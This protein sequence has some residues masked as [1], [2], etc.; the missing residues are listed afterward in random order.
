MASGFGGADGLARDKKGRVYVSDWKG[1]R[2]F[3]LEPGSDKANAVRRWIS[4]RGGYLF[5]PKDD[6]LLVPDMKAGTRDRRSHS[7]IGKSRL[8]PPGLIELAT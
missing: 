5:N 4:G 3:V 6:T 7:A 1:G 2:V 8:K